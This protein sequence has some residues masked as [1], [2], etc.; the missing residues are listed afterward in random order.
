MDKQMDWKTEERKNLRNIITEWNANR[1]DLFAVSEPNEELEFHGVMRFYFQDAGQKVAT[2]CIRVASSATTKD[3]IHTLIEKFRPDIRMLFVPEYALYEIHENGE[4]RKLNDEEQPLLVQLKWH[5]DDREGRFLLRRMDE[6]TYLPYTDMDMS[7]NNSNNSFIRKLSR[8]E[9]KEKKKK[10]KRERKQA[11][12]ENKDGIAERLYT[13]L[14]ETSFTRSISNPEAVMRRKR[15]QK[16]EKKLKEMGEQ[17]GSEAGGTLRIFGDS[18]NKDVPYKTLLLSSEDAA[19]SVVKELLEKYGLEKEDSQQYCLVQVVIPTMRSINNH[20]SFPSPEE[21]ILDDDDYPLR[22]ARN[23]NNEKGS[24]TFHIKQRPTD[25]QPRKRKK[26]QVHTKDNSDSSSQSDDSIGQMPYLSEINPDLSE[27]LHGKPK[28]YPLFPNVT[29][30][31]S[32]R[33]SST[34]G[35]FL[36]L[37]GPSIHPRHCVLAHTDGIVTVTPSSQNAETFVNGSKIFET[38]ILQHGMVVQFGKFHTFRFIDPAKEQGHTVSPDPNN[39]DKYSERQVNKEEKAPVYHLRSYETTFDADGN[40]ETISTP[41]IDEHSS[42]KS[43]DT[44]SRSSF[45]RDSSLGRRSY[46]QHRGKELILPAVLQ[47]WEDTENEFI[48][49]IT[50]LLDQSRVQ[51]KLAPTYALYMAA[52]YRASTHFRP[53]TKPEDRAIRLTLVMNK[54][55]EMIHKVIQDQYNDAVSL[56]FWL[57]NSAELLHFLKQD[58]HISAYT[59][60]SQDLLAESVQVAFRSLTSCL[61][62]DLQMAMPAFIDNLEDGNEE[63]GK[64]GNVLVVLFNTMALLRRCR[65]NAALTIQVFSQLFH[66]INLWLFNKLVS[67]SYHVLCTRVGGFQLRKRLSRIEAWAEKQGLEL[68][69]D[70]HLNR[71]VQAATLLQAPKNT[72]TDIANVCSSCFKLNSLQLRTLL[73]KYQPG[74]DETRIPQELIESVVKVAENTADELVR[75]DGQEVKLEEEVELQLPFLLPEDGYSCDIV[76]GVPVNLH[77]FIHPLEQAGLCHLTVQPNSAGFWTIYMTDQDVG[78]YSVEAPSPS[79]QKDPE[80]RTPGPTGQPEVVTMNL[81]KINNGMGLSIV[82]VK[83]TTQDKLGIYIKSVVKGG[84]AD[85]D[86]R[87]KGGDQLLR[88]D[89]HSLIGISQEKAAALMARTGPVVT[90]EVAKQAVFYHG[91]AALLT[92]QSPLLPKGRTLPGSRYLSERD[93]PSRVQCERAPELYKNPPPLGIHNSTSVPSLATGQF[94]AE[95]LKQ[96]STGNLSS[97]AVHYGPSSFNSSMLK[98]TEY[99]SLSQETK[100]VVSQKHGDAPTERGPPPYTLLI[101]PTYQNHLE[102]QQPRVPEEH[103]YQNSIVYQQQPPPA[104]PP[105][106]RVHPPQVHHGSYSSLHHSEQRQ[107]V[108]QFPVDHNRPLSTLVSSREQEQYTNSINFQQVLPPTSSHGQQ[109]RIDHLNELK[110]SRR[111]GPYDEFNPQGEP[112]QVT[113]EGKGFPGNYKVILPSQS[114]PVEVRHQDLRDQAKMEEIQE[115]VRRQEEWGMQGPN[116]MSTHMIRSRPQQH[117]VSQP[118]NQYDSFRPQGQQPQPAPYTQYRMNQVFPPNRAQKPIMHG[119]ETIIDN[120]LSQPSLQPHFQY[121]ATETLNSKYQIQANKVCEL[122]FQ[123]TGIRHG[124]PESYN[125][126]NKTHSEETSSQHPPLRDKEHNRITWDQEAKESDTMERLGN[127]EQM[128]GMQSDLELAKQQRMNWEKNQLLKQQQQLHQQQQLQ[129][130]QQLHQ[131]RQQQLQHQQL[132]EQHQLQHL[133][134]QLHQQRQQQLQHQQ[135]PEHHQLQHLPQQLQIQRVQQQHQQ[136]PQHQQLQQQH[137]QLPQHQQ[138]QQQHQQLPQ[139]QQLQQQT[140]ARLPP[141]D[142]WT[143]FHH[144]QYQYQIEDQVER[145]SNLQLEEMN[146]IPKFEMVKE[147]ETQLLQEAC[148][149]Q[150]ERNNRMNHQPSDVPIQG[151]IPPTVSITEDQNSSQRFQS[152]ISSGAMTLEQQGVILEEN[153][154]LPT[155]YSSG[156]LSSERQSSFEEISQF[157]NSN[158]QQVTEAKNRIIPH[159]PKKVSFQEPTI[160]TEHLESNDS[161]FNIDQAQPSPSDSYT[162]DDIDEELIQSQSQQ[163]RY[164][165]G[166]TPGVIGAQEVYRDPRQRIQAQRS[167]QQQAQPAKPEK[168]SFQQKM[169]MFAVS[170]GQMEPPKERVQ[171]SKAEREIEENI[172]GKEST[173]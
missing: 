96:S 125:L 65:V 30:V 63:D 148:Q 8:R 42:R 70:C 59:L 103:H 47:F 39:V 48:S 116:N 155:S 14:P 142:Q 173:C 95:T 85:Q 81:K 172:Q 60:D 83:G 75:S 104:R 87:L 127:L 73:E 74:P 121:G 144:E 18:I 4:E 86:G 129:K 117:F 40:V 91:L 2:K 7:E 33:S 50:T 115:E 34:D 131:Q 124:Q 67:R 5:K 22:I 140:R 151:C 32:E 6:E 58:R 36:Q 61:Q 149:K 20:S 170:E 128:H 68:A 88:V 158:I 23:F 76:R 150:H 123:Q 118:V 43:N 19:S 66:F 97:Q 161:E 156:H 10:E 24:L 45:G 145:L 108:P 167:R 98:N 27:V 11:E 37:L 163:P 169:K 46:D 135:L 164:E 26:K 147:P 57:A 15:Q 44:H 136:L 119:R 1:L 153:H 72:P 31:G 84:S 165:C 93:I 90:L 78:H 130:Q 166:I 54:V 168:L 105:P 138:L 114:Y 71:I 134:Q 132:P 141:R 38:T 80:L 82:A 92:Q 99:G 29:E 51:F 126:V 171:S 112:R 55:A 120:T 17:G 159:A 133:P 101:H 28:R 16:L 152:P 143:M 12:E 154:H 102:Q 35:Q 25:Y 13:E 64:A 157:P 77:D 79:D 122:E 69:A 3:V 9:K 21:Y 109:Y 56:A 160:I 94:P 100:P 113:Y 41:S 49:A 111:N 62:A 52:R 107:Q 106:Q 53:E 137:Q 162:L 110:D 146:R 89:G 139:H